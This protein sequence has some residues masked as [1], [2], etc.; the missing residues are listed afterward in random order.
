MDFE[1][2]IELLQ[3]IYM[4]T[5]ISPCRKIP[6]IEL[7]FQG[8]YSQEDFA[9]QVV[10]TFKEANIHPSRVWLQSFVPEDIFQWI[11]NDPEFG[12]QAVYLDERADLTTEGYENAIASLP[13]LAARGV[14][15]IAPS[16]W[17]LI[18]ANNETQKIVP[19]SYAIAARAAGLEVCR[20]SR[21]VSA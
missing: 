14:K 3:Y 13:D 6:E 8:D 16:I 2:S 1:F 12:R 5:F 18:T 20:Y 19:S 15:I 7:P 17:Q 11:E 9:Q 21:S 10:D 4:L